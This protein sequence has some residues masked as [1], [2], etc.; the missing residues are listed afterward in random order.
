MLKVC[1]IYYTILST[2]WKFQT[3]RGR[4]KSLR[5][6][7]YCS[8]L[9]KILW[10]NLGNMSSLVYILCDSICKDIGEFKSGLPISPFD[11]YS[12]NCIYYLEVK[13]GGIWK[14]LHRERPDGL[15]YFEGLLYF[16]SQTLINWMRRTIQKWK[17]YLFHR[18]SMRNCRIP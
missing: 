17:N 6:K 16:Y 11:F 5:V 18:S 3:L 10:W 15:F 1:L 12:I 4:G 8:E 9:L 13:C 2:T 14:I 7:A